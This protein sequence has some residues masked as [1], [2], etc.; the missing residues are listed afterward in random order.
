MKSEPEK[1]QKR[2]PQSQAESAINNLVNLLAELQSSPNHPLASPPPQAEESLRSLQ[3]LLGLEEQ[4]PQQRF[5]SQEAAPRANSP[6]K[7]AQEKVASPSQQPLQ[8]KGHATSSPHLLAPHPSEKL[9]ALEA[10]LTELEKQVRQPTE[11]LDPLIP[12]IVTLLQEKEEKTRQEILR[13]VVPAIDEVIRQRYQEEP[14]KLSVAIAATL[15][16]A[17]AH[18]IEQQPEEIANAI[19][20][21]VA[22][23]IR[24][25]IRLNPDAV[26]QALGPEMGRAIKVQIEQERDAMVDALYPVIGS[27]ISKYMAD[28]VQSINQ[29]VESAL[30][31]QGIKRKIRAK[32][33][34][35][36][37]AELILQESIQSEVKAAFLIHKASGFIISQAYP[38][39]DSQLSADII[40]GMLTAIRNFVN[41]CLARTGTISELSEIEYGDSKLV[42]EVAGYCYLAVLVRGNLSKRLANRLQETLSTIVLKCDRAIQSYDGNPDTA[43]EL[44]HSLLQQLVEPEEEKSQP[45]IT[46]IVLLLAVL[47]IVLIPVGIVQYRSHVANRTERQVAA[48]LDASPE[49]SVYRLTPEVSQGQLILTGRVP[50]QTLQVQAE[51]VA[52][53]IAPDLKL[54]N[55]IIPVDVPPDPVAVAAEVERTTQLLNQREGTAIASR[56]QDG[57]VTVEGSVAE[58]AEAARITQAFEAIPGVRSVITTV[59]TDLPAI[60]T[61]IYF[62]SNSAQLSASALDKL[63]SVQQF[64][65]QHPNIH[66]KVIGHADAQGQAASN[67]GIASDRAR[68]VQQSL[69]ER[70]VATGRLHSEV[71]TAFPPGVTSS[72][73]LWMSR[74]VRF[75]TFLPGQASSS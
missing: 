23:S 60:Q 2:S 63:A 5:P 34:G 8:K 57:V 38:S 36:S 48:A 58:A 71:S 32:I 75:E 27:T 14:Q 50:S 59:Q 15:P 24:E 29:Q 7:P 67:R 46:L 20:P 55:R 26:S 43:P 25:Q 4:E 13:A 70:G 74:C 41:D 35:V 16:R 1:D 53:A 31:I 21:E 73:P 22:L 47:S 62:D 37:E 28:V 44:A 68:A 40:A 30:S 18:Q 42:L 6:Q 49:L 72:Q 19:A 65:Q 56:Y 11:L 39:S 61:R 9:V 45:P 64:L 10:R 66:L 52:Q 3:Q 54:D 33:Q 51:Q 12:L 69:V 17:I